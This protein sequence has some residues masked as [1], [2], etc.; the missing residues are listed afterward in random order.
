MKTYT[1][2]AKSVKGGRR[3]VWSSDRWNLYNLDSSG[4]C[5]IGRNGG[6]G[7][8]YATNLLFDD[9]ELAV[10]RTKTIISM[11]LSITVIS[12]TIPNPSSSLYPVGFKL[13]ANQGSAEQ[14]EQSWARSDADSTEIDN[15][16][17][18]FLRNAEGQHSTADNT[19]LDIVITGTTPPVYGFVIGPNE[20]TNTAFVTVADTAILTVVTDE[21]DTFTVT[22]D[23]NGGSGAPAAQTKEAGTP[24]TLSS[25]EPVR[26]GYIFTGWNTAADGTGAT[27]AKGATY[28][29]DADATMYAQW[30]EITQTGVWVKGTDGNMHQGTI[31]VKGIDGEMHE[32][33]EYVKGADG[34]MHQS[35]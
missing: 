13:N 4:L 31:W 25:V 7:T 18:G 6:N 14:S 5:R 2:S 24:L 11:T 15:V 26:S 16:S 10:L 23:S 9:A 22:Y 8:N 19:P 1:L 21:A 32:A 28:S 20:K 17:C 35:S 34:N 33:T 29:I 12:G 3:G 27:F 30:Y